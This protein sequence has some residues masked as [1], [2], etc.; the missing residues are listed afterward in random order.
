MTD[1]TNPIY[2]II[3]ETLADLP[4]KRW[5]VARKKLAYLLTEALNEYLP[6]AR[7]FQSMTGP[8]TELIEQ[9]WPE[10]T[11]PKEAQFLEQA[12]ALALLAD[13]VIIPRPQDDR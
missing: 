11:R 13:H 9:R 5:P 6:G 3:E 10:G 12:I 4:H 7:D 2:R 8:L 1:T